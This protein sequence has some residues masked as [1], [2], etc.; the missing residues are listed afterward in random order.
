MAINRSGSSLH[1]ALKATEDLDEIVAL[2]RSIS[3]TPREEWT[4]P[5]ALTAMERL[6]D[7]LV[8]VIELA[9][10]NSQSGLIP[11]TGRPPDMAK[12]EVALIVGNFL[13]EATG[14]VPKLWPD[15]APA[16]PWKRGESSE[17][18]AV[19]LREIFQILGFKPGIDR[20]GDFATSKL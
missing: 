15:D 18:F 6:E 2:H 4:L 19:A 11:A 5:S 9:I 16:E 10:K 17:P 20:A 13:K 12:L 14:E 3:K 8:S 7:A 1:Q